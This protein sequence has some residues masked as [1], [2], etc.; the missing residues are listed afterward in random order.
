M[1]QEQKN[2]KDA[3]EDDENAGKTYEGVTKL[4]GGAFLVLVSGLFYM[5]YAASKRSK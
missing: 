3:P 2:I 4:G 5:S 1:M